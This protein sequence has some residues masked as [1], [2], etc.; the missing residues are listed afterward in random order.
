MQVG[1]PRVIGRRRQPIK[2]WESRGQCLTE[3]ALFTL[4]AAGSYSVSLI[5]MLPGNEILV[6]PLLPVLLL[7]HGRRAFNREYLWFYVLVL[8][9]LFGTIVGDL[10]RGSSSGQS[11]KGI[12]R[13]VFFILN[14]IFW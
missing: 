8:A 7:M 4:G 6:F 11:I 13:V 12:A 9:W 5:G 3:L 1:T 2:I 14:I 10:Y